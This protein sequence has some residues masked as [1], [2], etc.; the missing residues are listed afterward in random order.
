MVVL[1]PIGQPVQEQDMM[2][3]DSQTNMA[4][5]GQAVVGMPYNPVMDPNAQVNLQQ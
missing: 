5:Y 3:E 1:P 4:P 2:M